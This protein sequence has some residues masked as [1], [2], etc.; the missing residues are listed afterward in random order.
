[1]RSSNEQTKM[2]FSFCC[3]DKKAFSDDGP[4]ERSRLLSNNSTSSTYKKSANKQSKR[5]DPA[6]PIP[7]PGSSRGPASYPPAPSTKNRTP[8]LPDA[9]YVTAPTPPAPRTKAAPPANGGGIAMQRTTASR[10]QSRS[11]TTQTQKSTAPAPNGGGLPMQR[12][13]GTRGQP[14]LLQRK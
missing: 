4:T 3:N 8:K 14:R 7:I 5:A 11:S 1:M 12:T 13:K 2:V 6:K 9:I 10:G